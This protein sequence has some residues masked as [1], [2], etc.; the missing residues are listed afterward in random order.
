MK[1]QLIEEPLQELHIGDYV[2]V[3]EYESSEA[4]DELGG[5]DDY[6][7]RLCKVVF[8]DATGCGEYEVMFEEVDVAEKMN[9]L[10][11]FYERITA[12]PMPAKYADNFKQMDFEQVGWLFEWDFL[13]VHRVQHLVAD[14]KSSLGDYVRMVFSATGIIVDFEAIAKEQYK[15]LIT[16]TPTR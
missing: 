10:N 11:E 8:L 15:K 16:K 3:S 9:S 1:L 6:E 4:W 5:D 7:W 13:H 12:I 2:F 14:P